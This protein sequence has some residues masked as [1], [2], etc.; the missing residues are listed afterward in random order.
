MRTYRIPGINHLA[1]HGRLAFLEI[2]Q[3]FSMESD[4]P[5]RINQA[6]AAA[7]PTA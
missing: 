1:N 7:I 6:L 4:L 2:T 5:D 3:P